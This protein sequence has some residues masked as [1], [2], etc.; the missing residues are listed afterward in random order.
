MRSVYLMPNKRL[1]ALTSIASFA[2]ASM[3]SGIPAPS[4]FL[5]DRYPALG[6]L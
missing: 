4:C 5:G 3:C 2:L 6:W 1:K